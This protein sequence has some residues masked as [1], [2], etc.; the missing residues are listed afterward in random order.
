MAHVGGL[1]LEL[2]LAVDGLVLDESH[3][4]GSLVAYLVSDGSHVG[5]PLVV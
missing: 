4:D 1:E 2:V 5:E 3:E